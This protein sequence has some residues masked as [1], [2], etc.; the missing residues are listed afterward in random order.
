VRVAYRSQLERRSLEP[1]EAE[2]A[3]EAVLEVVEEMVAVAEAAGKQ[4]RG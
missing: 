2:A 3:L 4:H 1:E